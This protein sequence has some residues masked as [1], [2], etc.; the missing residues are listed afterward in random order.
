MSRS[1][2]RL[3]RQQVVDVA[4][5]PRYEQNTIF[6]AL[7]RCNLLAYGDEAMS[8]NDGTL[9]YPLRV[10]KLVRI[11]TKPGIVSNIR[12]T[13]DEYEQIL[14]ESSYTKEIYL[15]QLAAVNK[16]DLINNKWITKSKYNNMLLPAT[17]TTKFNVKDKV[18]C[19][20]LSEQLVVKGSIFA[21]F[22]TIFKG[23]VSPEYEFHAEDTSLEHIANGLKYNAQLSYKKSEWK[24]IHL[25]DIQIE[26]IR[27]YISL[28]IFSYLD[29]PLITTI[30]PR[31]IIR[32][33]AFF[34]KPKLYI[35]QINHLKDCLSNIDLMK[36]LVINIIKDLVQTTYLSCGK[37]TP[38]ILNFALK[39]RITTNNM[40]KVGSYCEEALFDVGINK[41]CSD[42]DI[43]LESKKHIT[44]ELD[45]PNLQ[46][47]GISN[48]LN[49]YKKEKRVILNGNLL[50]V[51]H[52]ELSRIMIPKFSFVIKGKRRLRRERRR[53]RRK[54]SE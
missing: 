27:H 45:Q 38:S 41:L 25:S 29:S 14:F 21:V 15:G 44:F 19:T 33:S 17:Y 13:N 39:R 54:Q 20:L 35:A 49:E 7:Q 6:E 26:T 36:I 46:N 50:F 5:I 52:R 8:L 10:K 4:L 34:G 53:Q 31:D 28:N 12:T 1:S 24:Q 47:I 18:Y 2:K 23:Q 40:L 48:I 16:Q 9:F 3:Q 32:E 22:P 43:N 51:Y 42:L 11:N 37:K 30:F